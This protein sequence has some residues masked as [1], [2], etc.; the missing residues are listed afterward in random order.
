[1]LQAEQRGGHAQREQLHR[2]G[3]RCGHRD[4][5]R[6]QQVVLPLVVSDAARRRASRV[7]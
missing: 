1:M 2:L 6:D 3:G 5:P 4:L 7:G